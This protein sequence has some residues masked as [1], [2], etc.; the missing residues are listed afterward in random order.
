MHLNRLWHGAHLPT[1]FN[2]SLKLFEDED[3]SSTLSFEFRYELAQVLGKSSLKQTMGLL[4]RWLSFVLQE[5]HSPLKKS[6]KIS[7]LCKLCLRYC[8]S[9]LTLVSPWLCHHC[10]W[11]ACPLLRCARD[12]VPLQKRVNCFADWPNL[13]NQSEPAKTGPHRLHNLHSHRSQAMQSLNIGCLD[14]TVI[15]LDTASQSRIT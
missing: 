4:P 1:N 12:E 6:S 5:N 15:K 11:L 3:R 10:P 8:W 9:S 2:P 13:R 7:V 14:G